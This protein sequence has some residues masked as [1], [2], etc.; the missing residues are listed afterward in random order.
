MTILTKKIF[1]S[2]SGFGECTNR[3]LYKNSQTSS[4][5][6]RLDLSCWYLFHQLAFHQSLQALLY[7]IMVFSLISTPRSLSIESAPSPTDVP[8]TRASNSDSPELS[9]TTPC[10][11]QVECSM[12]EQWNSLDV[13]EHHNVKRF[14]DLSNKLLI[15]APNQVSGDSFQPLSSLPRFPT[16]GACI[17][18]AN[19]LDGNCKSARS[20]AT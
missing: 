10:V 7:Q 4:I 16:I 6:V 15:Q 20:N 3:T 18:R 11:M 9:A 17:H 19:S 5:H 13:S 8:F 1:N 2:S 14:N 12:W